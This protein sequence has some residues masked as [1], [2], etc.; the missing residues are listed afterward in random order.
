MSKFI[1]LS[2]FYVALISCKSNVNNIKS[3]ELISADTLRSGNSNDS[4][5][6]SQ[7]SA[8][9]NQVLDC[10][11]CFK[12]IQLIDGDINS[13]TEK[14]IYNFLN[15][16]SGVCENNAEFSEYSNE[17]LFSLLSEK[18]EILIMALDKNKTLPLKSIKAA[19]ENPVNDNIELQQILKKIQGIEGYKVKD[20]LLQSLKV[21]IDKY[22]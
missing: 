14:Q 9:V 7:E 19:I 1:L 22:N 3:E 2:V 13:I 21:A 12:T 15:C 16:F 11:E 4:D 8:V 5:I 18:P 10:E 6:F 20:T 17:V